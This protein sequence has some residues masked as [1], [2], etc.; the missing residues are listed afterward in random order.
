MPERLDHVQGLR[1]LA[2]GGVLLYHASIWAGVRNLP[3]WLSSLGSAGVKLF[4]VISGLCMVW[5]LVG[6][7][8]RPG[9]LGTRAFLAR[10]FRR[11]VPP[12]YAAMALML[13]V[14]MLMHRFGGPSWWGSPMQTTFGPTSPDLA[15]NLL[16]HATF[17]H[18]L[19]PAFDRSIDG[20]YWSLATE[21]EFY[22]LL[23]L[24][25][26]IA[27]RL[28]LGWMLAATAA[29]SATYG[30]VG[31]LVDP[32]FLQHQVARDNAL[33]CLVEFGAGAA[34]VA[35]L[36]SSG[37][38]GVLGALAVGVLAVTVTDVLGA[39]AFTPFLWA[40]AFGLLLLASAHP[41]LLRSIATS[42]PARRLGEV[43]YSAY[44]V[45]GPVLMLLAIPLT[46]AELPRLLR[47]GLMFGLGLPLI[48]VAATAFHR[49]VETRAL[50]W[51][52]SARAT[53]ASPAPS[54]LLAADG[55]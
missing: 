28:G 43:S 3:E 37:A 4:F 46:H 12:Y 10:R 55:R 23:P 51:S 19:F 6:A 35:A 27:R 44:L 29:V 41:G 20:A 21:W 49:T 1:G 30:A 5:P 52:R 53:P 16:T 9:P 47:Q 15:G 14:S 40:L 45:H 7:D 33:F 26:P 54:P 8:G 50:R 22:L 31:L 24:L 25:V 34:C 2:V 32:D 39:S 11:I 36:R 13:V 48:L 17:T 38:S 18:G 42:R